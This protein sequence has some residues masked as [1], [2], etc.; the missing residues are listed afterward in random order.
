MCGIHCI[1]DFSKKTSA[2]S[3]SKMANTSAHRGLSTA[4][5]LQEI[6]DLYQ[7]SLGHNLLPINTQKPVFQPFTDKKR[8]Y[9][10]LFNGEIYNW[11]KID[12]KFNFQN[13]SQSDTETLFLYLIELS[14]N[15]SLW[16]DLEGIFA[17]I[18]LDTQNHQL[19]TGR[20]R[21]GVKPLYC[22]QDD[23][24]I[25]FSSEINPFWASGQVRKNICKEAV[26]E[27]LTFKFPLRPKTFFEN[28][29]EHPNSLQ[30]WDLRHRT[31]Q[32]VQGSCRKPAPVFKA[33]RVVADT[34]NLLIEAVKRQYP[35]FFPPA[36]MLSGGL[37]STLL[38]A[39][40]REQNLEVPA[41]SIVSKQQKFTKDTSFAQTAARLFRT[42]LE[43]IEIDDSLL[44][45]LPGIF[46][47]ADY[48][49]A[50]TAILPTYLIAQ[51]AKEERFRVL[52][53]GAGADELFA[54]YH[55]HQAYLIYLKK[56]K[57]WVWLARRLSKIPF[58]HR[59]IAKFITN[60]HP[61]P[62]QTFLNFAS[63]EIKKIKI[64]NF[65]NKSLL[66]EALKWD[67]E[68]YLFSDLLKVNDFWAMQA[69]QEVRV[70]YLDGLLSS[71]VEQIPANFLLSRGKKWILKE[72]LT[73]RGGKVFAQRRKQGFGIPFGHW[74][75]KAKHH[76]HFSFLHKP[77][78]PIRE[79][80]SSEEMSSIWL[81]H[82][83]SLADY[84]AELF[85]LYFLAAFLERQ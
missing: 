75:R 41:F 32:L 9:F 22:Y 26:N 79:F 7:F 81:K 59:Q 21:W 62:Q 63:M 40:A 18:F 46:A 53:S 24:K 78:H 83:N 67:R 33:Q 71:F 45:E 29:Y 42:P 17:F 16:G 49:I 82:Q 44:D 23:T 51:R 15:P 37:D 69:T 70:P 13:I 12:T 72:I 84:T 11:K 73:K 38:L 52:W 5:P 55:R 1:I 65:E 34:E 76:H 64:N 61:E 54:G 50:D 3:I 35:E 19:L 60:I 68:N 48:P 14:K 10:L 8:R 4:T 43:Q 85:A 77:Q 31:Q 80:L 74:I 6:K 20:D 56:P 2:E 39:L 30:I 28:I 57:T 25:L 66:Q 36:L 27:Y 58:R 47:K